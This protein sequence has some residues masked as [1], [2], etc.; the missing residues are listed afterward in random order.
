MHFVVMD[1]KRISCHC[2]RINVI[3]SNYKSHV[4]AIDFVTGVLLKEVFLMH[5]DM[6]LFNLLKHMKYHLNN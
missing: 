1:L 2:H 4:S 6:A 5:Q 3:M